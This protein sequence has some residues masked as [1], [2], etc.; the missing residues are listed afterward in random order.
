M[1]HAKSPT[2]VSAGDV[3]RPTRRGQH[4]CNLLCADLRIPRA[5]YTGATADGV[6]SV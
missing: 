6:G 5:C 2:V 1:K 4:L 3:H